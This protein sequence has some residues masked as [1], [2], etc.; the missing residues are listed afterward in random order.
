MPD[1]YILY[2]KTDAHLIAAQRR[3]PSGERCVQGYAVV[4]DASD[5]KIYE[6]TSVRPADQPSSYERIFSD[7]RM[8]AKC[9]EGKLIWLAYTTGPVPP[10]EISAQMQGKNLSLAERERVTAAIKG[11]GAPKRP[12]ITGRLRQRIARKER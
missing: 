6:T 5:G 8:L 12:A 2:S 1:M 9:D 7:T 11:R 4:C 10:A 3:L